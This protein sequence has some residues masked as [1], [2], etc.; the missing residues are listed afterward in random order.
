MKF[1]TRKTWPLVAIAISIAGLCLRYALFS[2]N[3]E[4]TAEHYSQSH[5]Y[6]TDSTLLKQ[7]VQTI[8]SLLNREEEYRKREGECQQAVAN[9]EKSFFVGSGD[10]ATILLVSIV[11]E[12]AAKA[13][14]AV[15]NKPLHPSLSGPTVEGWERI[16]VTIEGRTAFRALT[17]FYSALIAAPKSLCVERMEL[18]LDEYT[19]LLSFKLKLYSFTHLP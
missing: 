12:L 13:G 3:Q 10:S 15:K 9:W 1:I 4:R 5:L 19:G 14:L 11:E 18:H 2:P 16:G 6:S 17:A 8:N 7:R